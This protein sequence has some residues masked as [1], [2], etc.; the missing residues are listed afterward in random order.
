MAVRRVLI[1][2]NEAFTDVAARSVVVRQITEAEEVSVTNW[3]E[4]QLTKEV[5]VGLPVTEILE[6]VVRP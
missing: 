1:I 2:T 6:E 3:L 5:R 4:R